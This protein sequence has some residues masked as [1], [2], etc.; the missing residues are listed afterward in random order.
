M[1]LPFMRGADVSFLDEIETRGGRYFVNGQSADCLSILQGAGMNAIRLRVWNNPA[2]GYC[3]VERT[4]EMARRVKERGMMLGIDFHYSD[5]WADPGKQ[6][7]PQAWERLNFEDL[8][9]EVYH[10]TK[11][12]LSRLCEVEAPA[13]FVQVGNEI[14]YGFLWEDGR[15][16]GPDVPPDDAA[17]ERF[18]VLLQSGIR[19]VREVHGDASAVML[20]ID[21]GGDN[22]GARF[23]LDHVVK[24]GVDFDTIGLSFY[25]WWH[26][27]VEQFES[28]INDLA[29]RYRK[30]IIL[31]ETAYPWT[32][33][34]FVDVVE[35]YTPSV[36]AQSAFLE[37]VVD[38]VKNVKGG[39]G[40]GVF[41]WEPDAIPV[42]KAP[43]GW[44]R[45]GL[46]DH[47]GRALPG[48]QAFRA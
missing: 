9:S 48:L 12:V 6:F 29:K 40:K 33:M 17:W 24:A 7:K 36:D 39:F 1:S 18:I 4:L 47:T 20:H 26:G 35:S 3:G 14:T 42:A 10:F 34:D 13:D 46:F 19:A 23:F 27:G 45:V 31:A 5:G 22:R 8:T 2:D 21:R 44:A 41:Y 25:P 15:I 32:A 11:M 38:I 43:E 37:R 16:P 30:E 28:N